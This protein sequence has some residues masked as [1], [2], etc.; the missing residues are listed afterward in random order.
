MAVW[1]IF[2][3][4][5]KC[6]VAGSSSFIRLEMAQEWMKTLPYSI[7]RFNCI[8]KVLK[9]SNSLWQA[10]TSKRFE[11][12][13]WDWSW[14]KENSKILDNTLKKKFE[15]IIFSL[16]FFE[17]TRKNS[18]FDV[19]VTVLT[20]FSSFLQSVP[21]PHSS[22]CPYLIMLRDKATL[23]IWAYFDISKY[24]FRLSLFALPL[25]TK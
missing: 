22:I 8:Q 7:L 25:K 14:M 12:Q 5:F 6:D 4:S 15:N 13:I 24:D 23:V 17:L 11:L 21:I 18:F 16:F 3:R 9:R 19:A 1:K 2:K 20:I 10:L